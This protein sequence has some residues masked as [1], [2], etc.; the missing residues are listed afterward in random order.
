ME[1]Y[2]CVGLPSFT[3]AS[4]IC[5]EATLEGSLGVLPLKIL[6]EVEAIS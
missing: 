4:E 6:N 5:V 1:H 2:K 3:G